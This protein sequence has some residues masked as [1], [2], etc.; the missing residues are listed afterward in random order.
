M[1]YSDLKESSPQIL[2]NICK[3]RKRYDSISNG[4]S[5]LEGFMINYQSLEFVINNMDQY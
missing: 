1:K 3:N 5:Y 4:L 2:L